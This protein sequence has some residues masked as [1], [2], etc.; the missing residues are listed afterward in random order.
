MKLLQQG[1]W[2]PEFYVD[3]FLQNKTNVGKSNF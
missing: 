1:I 2:E 3:L